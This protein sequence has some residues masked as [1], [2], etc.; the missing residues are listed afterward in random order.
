LYER[1]IDRFQ[2]KIVWPH[3]NGA[4]WRHYAH[5]SANSNKRIRIFKTGQSTNEKN[6]LNKRKRP[7]GIA[8]LSWANGRCAVWDVTRLDTLAASHL[9]RA[10]LKAGTVAADTENR[11]SAKFTCLSA[12]Y[13]FVPVAI[14]TLGA[15]GDE[16]FSF[17]KVLGHRIACVTAE[18]RY[19]QFL[20]QRLAVRRGNA[21][22]VVGA[23]PV[24]AC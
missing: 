21:A 2:F 14:E 22:C 3:E 7:E 5:N 4:I 20:M 1:P 18:P 24:A 9:D 10:V 17:F 6:Y 13:K 12:R 8:V 16:A 11:Q 23:V 15:L 19:F